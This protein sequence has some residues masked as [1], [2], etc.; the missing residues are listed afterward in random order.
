M[1]LCVSTI[2]CLYIY[3]DTHR[4]ASEVLH[5]GWICTEL[6]LMERWMQSRWYNSFTKIISVVDWTVVY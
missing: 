1:T 6:I 2:M 4:K 5:E 3:E